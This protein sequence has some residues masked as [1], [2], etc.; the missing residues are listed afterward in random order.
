[1]KREQEQKW[2]LEKER[3]EVQASELKEIKDS[4]KSYAE[5]ISSGCRGEW[6]CMKNLS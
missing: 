1:M 6:T 4:E 2:E 3:E 5:E